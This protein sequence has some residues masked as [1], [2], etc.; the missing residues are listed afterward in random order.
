MLSLAVGESMRIW[1][2][3]GD[4]GEERTGGGGVHRMEVDGEDAHA[5]PGA[6]DSLH[7][8]RGEA[9]VTDSWCQARPEGWNKGCSHLWDVPGPGTVL[10]S[11]LARTPSNDTEAPEDLRVFPKGFGGACKRPPPFTPPPG[12]PFLPR[13]PV[14]LQDW[15]YVHAHLGTDGRSTAWS[16]FGPPAQDREHE[17][18]DSSKPPGLKYDW[19]AIAYTDGSAIKSDNGAQLVGA[20]V[21]MP[22]A[23][24]TG[25]PMTHLVAPGGEGPSNTI[26]RAELAAI[27]AALRLG[28]TTIMSDSACALWLIRRAV[29]E[30]MTLRRH[31]HRPLLEAIVD[32]IDKAESR[33]T[34]LK[35]KA[36][37]GL[38]GNEMADRAAKLAAEGAPGMTPHATRLRIPLSPCSG[39]SDRTGTRSTT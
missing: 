33:V 39:R 38:Y 21:Y 15:R 9:A 19:S 1:D 29:V 14:G 16:A 5:H 30:P 35:C 26:N 31:L 36:H 27:W 13:H 10:A 22:C 8:D 37:T 4:R 25:R 18:G 24:R 3:A 32:L 34:L 28:A 23:P 2:R 6:R 12:N 7:L 20:A 17:E 11:Q